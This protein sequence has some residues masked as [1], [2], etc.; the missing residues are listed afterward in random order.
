[1]QTCVSAP[2]RE[3]KIPDFVQ[4]PP[5][6]TRFCQ[7]PN[8]NLQAVAHYHHCYVLLLCSTCVLLFCSL[9]SHCRRGSIPKPHLSP[10]IFLPFSIYVKPRAGSRSR[11]PPS[12]VSVVLV[13]DRVP[14]YPSHTFAVCAQALS[15]SDLDN[16]GY[17]KI[18]RVHNQNLL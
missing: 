1:M 8:L 17:K 5:G 11:L 2:R 6:Y 12:Y 7:F 10:S 15:P 18:R 14:G 16:L 3:K 4:K 9:K 13:Q